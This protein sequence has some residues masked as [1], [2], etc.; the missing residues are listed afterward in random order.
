MTLATIPEAC[1]EYAANVGADR[2]DVA[3]ILTDWDT[4][5]P[6]PFYLGPM[7]PHPEEDIEDMDIEVWRKAETLRRAVRI[8]LACY[9]PTPFDDE[10]IE[11]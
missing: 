8:G 1:R 4:W 10:D 9:I 6:N 11:F 7:M 5:E 2:Q 3:W